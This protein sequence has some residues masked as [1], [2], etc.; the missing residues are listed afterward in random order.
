[1]PARFHSNTY[2]HLRCRQL[3]VE[4]FRFLTVPQSPLLQFPGFGIYICDLLKAR[5]VVCS[6]NDHCSAPFSRAFWLVGTTKVYSGP[7]SRHCHGIIT[8]I[9]WVVEH[10][11]HDGGVMLN[12]SSSGLPTCSTLRKD[13]TKESSAARLAKCRPFTH[14]AIELP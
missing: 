1:M 12:A 4:L 8:L 5:M 14:E 2:L 11:D 10:S 3:T 6:Y 7:G 9:N 13:L